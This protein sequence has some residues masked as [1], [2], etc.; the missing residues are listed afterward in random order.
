MP[1]EPTPFPALKD[2]FENAPARIHDEQVLA[3]FIC[4]AP[5]DGLQMM[6][7]TFPGKLHR[8]DRTLFIKTGGNFDGLH[9]FTIIV[10]YIHKKLLVMA[11]L[12][13]MIFL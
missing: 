12:L 7:N 9:T 11:F 2:Y 5:A 1:D 10:V 13:C 8:C 4:P 3:G 6:N